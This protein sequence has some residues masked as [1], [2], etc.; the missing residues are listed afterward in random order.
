MKVRLLVPRV[1]KGF[2]QS[3]GDILDLPESQARDLMAR[4]DAEAVSVVE[5]ATKKRK[6][7]TRND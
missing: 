3:I 7:E 4:G 5:R 2:S 1:G 6:V